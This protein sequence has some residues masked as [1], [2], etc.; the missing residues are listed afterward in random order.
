MGIPPY[1]IGIGGPDLGPLKVVTTPI[2]ALR[3]G[4][5]RDFNAPLMGA[6][7]EAEFDAALIGQ[8]ARPVNVV[9]ATQ[10]VAS[11]TIDFARLE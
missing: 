1:E 8:T 10:A 2:N 11:V 3:S 4:R 6:T 9:L 5:A 7:I